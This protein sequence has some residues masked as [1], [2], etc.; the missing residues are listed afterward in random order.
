MTES[1]R[2]FSEVFEVT[3]QQAVWLQKAWDAAGVKQGADAQFVDMIESLFDV[4]DTTLCDLR[5][6][7]GEPGEKV[8]AY[9]SCELQC[10][11]EGVALVLQRFL[12]EFQLEYSI[13]ITYADICSKL[14][15]G[16]FGGGV[17]LVT[18]KKYALLDDEK[19]ME[20]AEREVACV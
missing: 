1:Y 16:Q 8:K 2:I 11:L 18:A 5:I 4:S 14:H 7:A 9:L 6:Q 20:L 13:G 19:I 12:Q 17:V 3:G 15:T 10:D